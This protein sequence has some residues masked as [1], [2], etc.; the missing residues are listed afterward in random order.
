M[1]QINKNIKI[2]EQYC[3]EKGERLTKKRKLVLRT[4]LTSNKALSAYEI[5]HLCKK[6]FNEVLP[7]MSVYRMLDF[8]Q[9]QGL[10]HRLGLAN[11]Y[12][13]CSQGVCDDNNDF[14][15]FLICDQCQHVEEVHVDSSLLK[16]LHEA[17]SNTGFKLR[18]PQ[19]EFNGTCR[20]CTTN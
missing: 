8:L 20:H 6:E 9:G 10:V 12:V 14:V 15:Q 5:I 7:A 2:A 13:A 1:S 3:K 4:L 17:I 11:K 16:K 18:S 19:I